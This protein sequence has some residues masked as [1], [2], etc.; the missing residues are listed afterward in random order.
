MR[1]GPGWSAVPP[2]V[3]AE[4]LCDFEA[5]LAS[6]QVEAVVIATPVATHAPLVHAALEAGKHVL[7]EK[8]LATSVREAEDLVQLARAQG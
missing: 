2:P 4:L 8:P 5:V 1:I 6:S 7:V 3:R